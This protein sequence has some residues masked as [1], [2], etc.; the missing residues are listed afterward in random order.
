MPRALPWFWLH[1][2]PASAAPFGDATLAAATA[3]I[4][5][6]PSMSPGTRIVI[7]GSPGSASGAAHAGDGLILLSWSTSGTQPESETRPGWQTHTGLGQWCFP[8]PQTL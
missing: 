3:R 2:H 4:Y 1:L 5:L 6:V 7:W 8:A